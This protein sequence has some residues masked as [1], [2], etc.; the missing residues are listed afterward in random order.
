[1]LAP[2]GDTNE[3]EDT[4]APEQFRFKVRA[5]DGTIVEYSDEF[6]HV[7]G[8]SCRMMLIR[9]LACSSDKATVWKFIQAVNA[10]VSGARQTIQ[11]ISFRLADA[12]ASFML[13]SAA[14]SKESSGHILVQLSYAQP[15]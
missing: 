15:W 13:M 3:F 7:L 8:R 10:S 12:S 4:F 5:Q 1:M 14:K 11:T 9:E 2:I 6:E